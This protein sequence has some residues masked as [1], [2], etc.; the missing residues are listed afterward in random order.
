MLY[1]SVSRIFVRRS[2]DTLQKR[3]FFT[4]ILQAKNNETRGGGVRCIKLKFENA[5]REGYSWK[6]RKSEYAIRC[7]VGDLA[8]ASSTFSSRRRN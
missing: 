6:W 4:G 8:R 2:R 5:I 3:P 7:G 1:I